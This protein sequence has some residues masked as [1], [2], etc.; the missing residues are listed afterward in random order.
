MSTFLAGLPGEIKNPFSDGKV[1]GTGVTYAEYARQPDVRRG[2]ARWEMTRG[3][4]MAFSA[5]PHKWLQGVPDKVTPAMKWGSLMDCLLLTPSQFETRFA[6]APS[7][8][9][10]KK[11]EKSE[12]RNDDRIEAV[13]EFKAQNVGK[14][15]V[16]QSDYQ[17]AEQNVKAVIRNKHIGNLL[18]T[19]D[20]QVMVTAKY[21]DKETGIELPV[22]C[23]MDLVPKV[24][25]PLW[26]KCLGDLKLTTNASQGAWT[27][28]V[29]DEWYHIQAA[30]YTDLYRCARPD[31][32][33][34]DWFNAVSEDHPPYE[35]ALWLLSADFV[36]LG[37]M[38]YI[39][40]LQRYCISLKT[41]QWPSYNDDPLTKWITPAPYMLTAA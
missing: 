27:R 2:D 20:T 8:Y 28:K 39:E 10:N 14:E 29:W 3:E 18:K 35:S 6:I 1:V 26:G 37:R 32:D 24:T 11:G 17:E 9:L 13:R 38:Q 25:D 15:I 22:K 16:S 19:A 23:L 21:L 7:H 34:T 12:W 5:C 40:A 4:L 33:R 31:E 41:G 36:A 30:F